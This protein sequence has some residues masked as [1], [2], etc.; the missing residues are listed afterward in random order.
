MPYH[1][2]VSKSLKPISATVGTSGSKEMRCCVPTAMARNLPARMCAPNAG[3]PADD[4]WVRPASR[5]VS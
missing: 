1:C 4:A 3:S 5:S 2:E